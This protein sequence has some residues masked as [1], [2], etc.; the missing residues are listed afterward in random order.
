MLGL[1]CHSGTENKP[2]KTVQIYIITIY[3]FLQ[4]LAKEDFNKA[5]IRISHC[6]MMSRISSFVVSSFTLLGYEEA[7]MSAFGNYDY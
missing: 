4:H 6:A 3:S 2:L 5:Q 1:T 7:V